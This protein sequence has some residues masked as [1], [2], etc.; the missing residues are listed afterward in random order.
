MPLN[1]FIVI[2]F[3]PADHWQFSTQTFYIIKI[4]KNAE[5]SQEQYLQEIRDN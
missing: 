1:G 2:Y 3:I 5:S 4:R